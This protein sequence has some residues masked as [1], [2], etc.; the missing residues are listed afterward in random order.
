MAEPDSLVAEASY[1]LQVIFVGKDVQHRFWLV[2][3]C[4]FGNG[5][6]FVG[7]ACILCLSICRCQCGA[8][9]KIPEA[10]RH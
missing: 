6:F 10:D 5:M 8:A 9:W 1:V 2:M 4:F 3:A 7:N